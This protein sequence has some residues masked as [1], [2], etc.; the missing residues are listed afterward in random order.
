MS[1]KILIDAV[2]TYA[3]KHYNR[4][5]WDYLV[6][7]WSDEDIAQAIAGANTV[8]RAIAMCKRTVSLMDEMRSSVMSEAF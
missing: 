8:S 5:G 4:D 2:R 6:E 3:T 7:C 1:E